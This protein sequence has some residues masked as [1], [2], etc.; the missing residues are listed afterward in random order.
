MQ[1]DKGYGPKRIWKKFVGLYPL[2]TICFRLIYAVHADILT[3]MMHDLIIDLWT[4]NYLM[5]IIVK[6]Y[7][8][9]D[10][11]SKINFFCWH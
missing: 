5:V 10:A 7:G 11:A 9:S 1:L 2:F 4:Y 6:E 8:G 3:H